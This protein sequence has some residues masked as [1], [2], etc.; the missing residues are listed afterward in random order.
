MHAWTVFRMSSIMEWSFPSSPPRLAVRFLTCISNSEP[1]PES[2]TQRARQHVAIP[3]SDVM[4]TEC[5]S[6][7]SSGTAGHRT[8]L[9]LFE[10]VFRLP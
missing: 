6:I 3:Q 5:L 8:L 9:A 2:C 7:R 1:I 4:R 10:K